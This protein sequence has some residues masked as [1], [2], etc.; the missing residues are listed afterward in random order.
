MS[1]YEMLVAAA[2]PAG[3]IICSTTTSPFRAASRASSPLR[4]AL[5]PYISHAYKERLEK[6]SSIV[7]RLRFS[8]TSTALLELALLSFIYHTSHDMYA[9]ATFGSASEKVEASQPAPSPF[10]G[11]SARK[12][13]VCRQTNVRPL[14]MAPHVRQD[15]HDRLF[16]K[17]LPCAMHTRQGTG[18]TDCS[19][20]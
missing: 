19:A 11:A 16:C 4:L 3:R 9:V 2:K 20:P 18:G 15:R 17:L 12:R 5:H 10:I 6:F 7:P 8:S 14:D 13:Y 1:L